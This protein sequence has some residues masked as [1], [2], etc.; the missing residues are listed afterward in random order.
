MA[1]TKRDGKKTAQ[2]TVGAQRAPPVAQPVLPGIPEPEPSEMPPPVP[3]QVDETGKDTGE[4]PGPSKVLELE[5]RMDRQLEA[6]LDREVELETEKRLEGEINQGIGQKLQQDLELQI[7][8]EINRQLGPAPGPRVTDLGAR[9]LIP[10]ATVILAHQPGSAKTEPAITAGP[11][12]EPPARKKLPRRVALRNRQPPEKA[13]S[14]DGMN[15]NGRRAG[16]VNGRGL[17]NRRGFSNGMMNGEGA[18]NGRG[19]VNGLRNR[20]GM[21]NGNGMTNG[22]GMV[23]GRRN[24]LTNGRQGMVGRW[25]R[26]NGSL[27]DAEGTYNGRGM[28]NGRGIVNGEGITNGRRLAIGESPP[29]PR[30]STG[31]VIAVVVVVI[32]LSVAGLYFMLVQTEKGVHVDGVFSDWAGVAKNPD[33]IA[34]EANP[35]INIVSCSLAVDG[36]SASVYL[37]TEGKMLGGRDNGVDSVYFFFD[38]DQDISTGYRIDSVGAELVLMVDG[39]D[40]RVS[41]AGLYRFSRDGARPANDW[42]FRVAT[43]SCRAAAAGSELEAQTAL[44]DLGVGAGSK[45]NVLAYTKDGAGGED[46]ASVMSTEKVRLTAMWSR[47]GPAQTDP[48]ASGVPLLMV[49]LRAF[50]GNASVASITVHASGALA[51]GDIARLSMKTAAGYEVPGATGVL[52]NGRAS[53]AFSPPLAVAP[54]STTTVTVLGTFSVSSATG[55]AV[56][57]SLEGGRDIAAG[58]RAITVESRTVPLTYIGAPSARIVIDGAFLDWTTYPEHPDPKGDVAEPNIDVTGFQTAADG[59]SLFACLRV[60]G[61]M[62]GGMGIPER[63]L[64]PPVQQHGGGGGPVNLPVLVG[65]DAAFVFIDSDNDS[66][67]GYSGGNLPLGADFLANFTGQYGRI[68]YRMLHRFVGSDRGA[69]SWEALGAIDAAA[70]GTQLEA[71]L[72]LGALGGPSGNVSLFYYTTNWRLDRDIGDRVVLDLAQGAGGRDAGDEP[73]TYGAPK[74]PASGRDIRPLHAPEFKDALW[75]AAGMVVLFFIVRRRR[76]RSAGGSRSRA[77]GLLTR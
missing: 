46:F 66:S 71:R 14:G 70:A 76:R 5:S 50:G 7:D 22:S 38:T 37:R 60:D 20:K 25:A 44:P 72:A 73:P 61:E 41:A 48:G 62:M 63:K 56:G 30:R 18:V 69:W 51:D 57:L 4:E 45:F 75:P 47:V 59:G 42:N 9:E 13:L 58:T 11:A 19:A 53:L 6:G 24:G 74:P 27:T 1:R 39:Y 16:L 43:G 40:G 15:G 65:E 3:F 67:T 21:S 17:R 34:D 35:E 23:N 52:G 55:K 12:A 49:E 29:R 33:D 32:M 28:V 31:P 2:E 77:N 64:R 8:G 54:G 10:Y 36:P 68:N 26:V